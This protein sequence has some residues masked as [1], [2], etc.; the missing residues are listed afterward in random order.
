MLRNS[1]DS[2]TYVLQFS[3]AYYAERKIRSE[4]L[5]FGK[6]AGRFL[7][8][9]CF[10][11]FTLI[12][13]T[14]CEFFTS[15]MNE[16]DIFA[17]DTFMSIKAK[18]VDDEL[19]A[20]VEGEITRL[21]SLF[22]VTRPD[23]DIAKLNAEGKVEADAD[24]VELI[25]L[26]KNMCKTT[27]GALDISVYPVVSLWGFTN[28]NYR[29]PESSE[30][31]KTL[32]LVDYAQI[33][34]DGNIVQLDEGMEL[35]LGAVAKGYTSD[36]I[37]ELLRENGVTSAVINLGGNVQTI[38]KRPDGKKWRVAVK[39]P[40]ETDKNLLVVEIEDTAVITSGNYER[41]FE[42]DGKRYCHIIDS[43][44]GYPADN[45]I[46]SMTVIGKNGFE[47]DAL[48]T[49][50]F[51]MRPEKAIEFWKTL[52]DIEMIYVTDEEKIYITEGISSYCTNTSGLSIEVIGRD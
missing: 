15:K 40:F 35:D 50:L 21:D 12:C 44:T 47:C 52:D 37:C 5:N 29:V 51:V 9:G 25:E 41:Y 10:M 7:T 34:I 2:T 14:S 32:R 13:T 17:M 8:V 27:N 38:G 4:I 16:I 3:V 24:T 42:A 39:N 28:G 43:K 20:D 6:R 49:A 36:K 46:V 31:D 30:I 11:L 45:G 23:S 22:S 26:A 19:L 18:G 1:C 48:S 33:K